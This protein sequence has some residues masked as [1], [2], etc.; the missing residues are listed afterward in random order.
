MRQ[1]G[2]RALVPV[3]LYAKGGSAKTESGRLNLSIPQALGDIA[4]TWRYRHL[5]MAMA[6]EDITDQHRRTT[7]GPLWLLVNYLLFIGTFVL[8]FGDNHPQY[9]HGAYMAVGLFVWIHISEVLNQG[10]M[11]F[12]REEGFIK[13]TPL[14]LPVYVMRTTMQILMRETFTLVGCLLFL[15]FTQFAWQPILPIALLGIALIIFATPPAIF[16]IAVFG[17][18][19]PDSQFIVANLV[20][21]GMF[22]TPI[23]WLAS[24]GSGLRQMLARL[25]P[26]THIIAL[27]RD[28]VVFGTFHFSGLVAAAAA[29]VVLW[30]L[31][32][33]G[34][35]LVRRKIIFWL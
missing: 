35:A 34:L 13:G 29:C 6:W 24:A 26:F 5:W 10:V 27:V 11:L 18:Y 33:A 32:L 17:A 23:F 19:F 14:P 16:L 20:R 8:V 9:D 2:D 4:A 15:L 3:S 1:A 25:N 7:L 28:P 31:A 30:A 21:I 12:I 22:L